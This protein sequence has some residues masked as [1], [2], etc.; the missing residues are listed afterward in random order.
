MRPLV[1]VLDARASLLRTTVPDPE[2]E[3]LLHEPRH[4][5]A[6]DAVHAAAS[7]GFHRER[8]GLLFFR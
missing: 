6:E 4:G 7:L 2:E 1:A 3:E 8:V 5:D